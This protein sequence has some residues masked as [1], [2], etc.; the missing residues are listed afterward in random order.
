M[1]NLSLGANAESEWGI[2]RGRKEPL[3][4]M[5]HVWKGTSDNRIIV[6]REVMQLIQELP[7]PEPLTKTDFPTE[8]SGLTL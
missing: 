2:F 7:D 3:K 1:D 5:A 4:H 6:E 8:F